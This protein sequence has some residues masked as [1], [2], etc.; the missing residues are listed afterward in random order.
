MKTLLILLNR[1]L[2][3]SKHFTKILA[4]SKEITSYQDHAADFSGLQNKHM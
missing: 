3:D 1:Q 4:Q 2:M